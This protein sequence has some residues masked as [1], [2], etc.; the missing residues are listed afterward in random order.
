VRELAP[1]KINLCLSVGPLR[2]DG[3]HEVVSVM[4]SIDLA[5]SLRLVDHVGD[6]DE[7]RCPGVDGPNLA[8]DAIAAFRELAGWDGPPQLLEIEK[9]IPVAAGLGG[10]SA[11]AAAALRLLSRRAGLGSDAELQRIATQ[12]GA[13]VPSQLQ[14]GRWLAQGAGE[15]LEPL[16]D[17]RPLGILIVPSHT[18]L[19]TPAVYREADRLGLARSAAELQVVLEALDPSNPEPVNDLEP[20]AR[21]LDPTIDSAIER[22]SGEGALHAFV[23]GSGPTVVGLFPTLQAARVAAS[24]LNESGVDAQASRAVHNPSTA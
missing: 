1:A 8:A 3:R 16:P 10:G 9:R 24:R 22:V 20:A 12:L 18:S 14:P 15:R 6:A 7:V 21:S 13:D 2:A 5:D 4:Q 23:T 19:S 17:P 11:D